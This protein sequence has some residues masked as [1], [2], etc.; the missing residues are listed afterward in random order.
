MKWQIITCCM[1]YTQHMGLNEGDSG[2]GVWHEFPLY[3]V[4]HLGNTRPIFHR[5]KEPCD[6]YRGEEN[7]QGGFQENVSHMH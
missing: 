3:F 4:A 6:L 2:C 7:G 1:L 5:V